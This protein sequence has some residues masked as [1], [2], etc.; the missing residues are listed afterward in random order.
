MEEI[1]KWFRENFSKNKDDRIWFAY[2]NQTDRSHIDCPCD[3]RVELSKSDEKF[4]LNNYFS[5]IKTE[6]CTIFQNKKLNLN[7]R[8]ETNLIDSNSPNP[9][10]YI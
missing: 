9:S 1:K 6:K 8:A 3:T 4:S 2:D 7:Q 10:S 5:H